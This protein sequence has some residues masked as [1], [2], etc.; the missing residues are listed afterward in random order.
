MASVKI[1]IMEFVSFQT[2]NSELKST[3]KKLSH[4]EKL[5]KKAT[6]HNEELKKERDYLK[7]KAHKYKKAAKS[8]NLKDARRKHTRSV[9]VQVG[10][11]VQNKEDGTSEISGM[12]PVLFY[13]QMLLWRT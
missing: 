2:T 5:Y 13:F 1:K 3:Q 11:T 12:S 9:A 7:K 6:K 8:R 4:T 10:E